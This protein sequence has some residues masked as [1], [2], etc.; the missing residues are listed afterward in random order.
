MQSVKQAWLEFND[1]VLKK[2]WPDTFL[3]T[4][5]IAF[6]A[7]ITFTIWRLAEE[8]GSTFSR[9]RILEELEAHNEE[10]KRRYPG[11]MED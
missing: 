6:M 10:M 8:E 11:I 1:E 7:G 3:F 5:E 9:R 4:C 2:G